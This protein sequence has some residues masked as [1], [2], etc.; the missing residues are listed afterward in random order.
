MLV[1]KCLEVR[2]ETT[3]PEEV[4]IYSEM[5]QNQAACVQP[6]ESYEKEGICYELSDWS[7]IPVTLPPI[8]R[9]VRQEVLYDGVEGI[10]EL[11]E[12][13]SITAQDHE[14]GQTVLTAGEIQNTEMLKEEWREGFTFPLTFH[15]Y[16][17]DYYQLADRLIPHDEDRPGLEGCE[18]SLLELVGVSS[19][20]YA[21]TDIRWEG[22]AY[23][24]G[25]GVWCRDAVASGQMLVRDYQVT[26]TGTAVFPEQKMWQTM[27][28]YRPEPKAPEPTVTTELRPVP[29]PE[30]IEE[31][32]KKPSKGLW[33]RITKILLITI[34]I[35]AV[36]FLGGLFVLLLLR[37]AKNVRSCYNKRQNK[38]GGG[39]SYVHRK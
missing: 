5:K 10:T 2:A 7:V 14:R 11:P 17:A 29:S 23:E 26:Y 13:I 8:T 16:H 37:V 21:I 25:D 34:G 27:A 38:T 6:E 39:T 30:I 1:V 20:E 35:G 36:L 15:H 22:D 12:Q 33:E 9:K 28:V 18:E 32:E 31:A 19:E 3:Y 24:D 4:T